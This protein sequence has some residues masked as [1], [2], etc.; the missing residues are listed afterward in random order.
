A[1]AHNL[2]L[3][4][5]RFPQCWDENETKAVVLRQ[6]ENGRISGIYGTPTFFINNQTF[7]GP[8]SFK[9]FDKAIQ[10]ELKKDS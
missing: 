7:V 5:G 6:L 4:L 8:K 10:E 2:S 1:V 3:D 9:R